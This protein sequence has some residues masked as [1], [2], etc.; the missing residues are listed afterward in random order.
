MN[1]RVLCL[2]NDLLADDAFGPAVAR[3]IRLL[4]LKGVEVLESPETG[5]YLLEYIVNTR[6]LVVIDTIASGLVA[7][8]TVCLFDEREL[9]TSPGSSP[10]YVGLF[11]TLV[12]ARKL[13]LPTPD[14][15]FLVVVEGEDLSTVGGPMSAAVR[16]AIP[17]VGNLVQEI[18]GAP[19]LS[20]R[21][22]G[23]VQAESQTDLYPATCGT[24]ARRGKHAPA[25]F[26]EKE[27]GP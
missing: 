3:H 23:P 13:G 24:I 6:R 4:D 12:V 21:K 10:H 18:I 26:P 9:R 17:V 14:E 19:K 5:F 8:G 27:K 25:L 1:T 11:E 2:G 15:V 7:A 16:A 22:G 20:R